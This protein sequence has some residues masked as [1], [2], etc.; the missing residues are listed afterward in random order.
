MRIIY[1]EGR[2]ET[3][4][5]LLFGARKIK[6]EYGGASEEGQGWVIASYGLVDGGGGYG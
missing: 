6:N 5:T 1:M 3:K 4:A 2:C